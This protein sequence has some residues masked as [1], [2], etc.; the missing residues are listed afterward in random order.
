MS[1]RQQG[2]ILSQVSKVIQADSRELLLASL[3]TLFISTTKDNHFVFFFFFFFFFRVFFLREIIDTVK[4]LFYIL[5]FLHLKIK[6]H[7][8]EVQN[9]FLRLS[10]TYSLIFF[11]LLLLIDEK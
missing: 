9:D 6:I 11:V 1:Q 8:L 2:R 4:L 3:G 5:K 10:I 7:L